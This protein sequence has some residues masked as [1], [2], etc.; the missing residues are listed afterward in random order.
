MIL[1]AAQTKPKRGD[2]ESNLVDHYNLIELASENKVDL[3]VFPEMSMTGYERDKALGLA[4][5]E[6]DSRLDILRQLSLDKQMMIIS[7][8]PIRVGNDLYIGAFIFKPDASVSIYIKQFLHSGEEKFFKST[9]D[10]NPRI[11]LNKEL[12]SLSICADIDHPSHAERAFNKGTSV[13]I[14]SLFFTPTGIPN[15]YKTLSDYAR[16]HKMNILMSNFC[17][18]SWELDSGGQ[19]GF[20]DNHG[21]LIANLNDQDAGLLIVERVDNSWA[22]KTIIYI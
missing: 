15:A 10:C 3:I 2:I 4:F 13:Y 6:N 8:A 11:E 12:I 20:W 22:G 14:A 9:F 17:G 5:T 16:R 19:S 1:A 18:Q 7:G 21:N